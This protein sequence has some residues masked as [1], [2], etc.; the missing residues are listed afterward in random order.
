MFEFLINFLDLSRNDYTYF[1]FV[2]C[3]NIINCYNA[4]N[5]WKFPASFKSKVSTARYSRDGATYGPNLRV[6]Y[7]SSCCID[8]ASYTM[9]RRGL[10]GILYKTYHR[11][12]YED[13]NFN[14]FMKIYQAVTYIACFVWRRSILSM[15]E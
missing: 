10:R 13:I 6:T 14:F 8:K 2:R 1:F 11:R 5:I 4:G 12:F 15:K 9:A 3:C 7:L